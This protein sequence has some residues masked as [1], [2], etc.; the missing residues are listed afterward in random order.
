MAAERTRL[1]ATPS[2]RR[3]RLKGRHGAR[4]WTAWAILAYD[5]DASPSEPP[6]S[7]AR[8]GT[9]RPTT[10]RNAEWPCS[11]PE[12]RPFSLHPDYVGSARGAW[13][14]RRVLA[15]LVWFP[16]AAT[17]NRACGSPAHGSPTFFTAGIRLISLAR[18]GGAWA[19]RRFQRG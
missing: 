4:T 18:P 6:D 10:T 2:M 19:R 13:T 11:S 17:S 15:R 7:I 1:W 5:L 14:A 9:T 3:S 8:V 16:P 12:A